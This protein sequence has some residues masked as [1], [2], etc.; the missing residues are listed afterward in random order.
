MEY[1]FNDQQKDEIISK[2]N[3]NSK[4][5]IQRYKGLGE[6]DPEQLWETTMNPENR[7]MLQVQVEDAYKADRVFETLMGENVAPRK[8]FI[9]ANAKYVKNI[10]L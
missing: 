4:I 6:M 2:L 3:P 5:T 9:E 7:K 8:E 10:D 1:A